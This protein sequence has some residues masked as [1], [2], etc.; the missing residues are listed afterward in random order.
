MRRARGFTII[1]LLI[2]LGL[3]GVLMAGAFQ[4]NSVF[5][6]QSARQRQI[7]EMQQSLRISMSTI[8]RAVRGSGAGMAN[9][10][11]LL[12]PGCSGTRNLFRVQMYNG[13]TA[14]PPPPALG[15]YD[16]TAGDIDRDPD[17]LRVITAIDTGN[18]LATSVS[19]GYATNISSLTPLNGVWA[20]GDYLL[21]VDSKSATVPSYGVLRQIS[22]AVPGSTLASGVYNTLVPHQ[23]SGSADCAN[24]DAA[25]T[26]ALPLPTPVRRFRNQIYFRVLKTAAVGN[27]VDSSRLVVAI[28]PMTPVDPP[29]GST[30]AWSILADDIEDLQLALLM[31][32]GRVC[33]DTD[34]PALAP[35]GVCDPS[36][37]TALRVTLTARQVVNGLTP[38]G[39]EAQIGGFEDNWPGVAATDGR[40]RRSLTSEITLRN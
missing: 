15:T 27:T 21:F 7:G 39:A 2:A 33:N 28:V 29:Q 6:S 11:M 9:G 34:D 24:N 22:A 26:P 36:Q 3:A 13:L 20:Q 25:L 32:D 8:E 14:W 12:T 30:P 17:V 16:T 4:I 23:T 40:V 1:E 5:S 19:T 10:R 35:T 18:A 31:A 38:K 37:A